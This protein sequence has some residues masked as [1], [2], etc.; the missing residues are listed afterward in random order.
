VVRAPAQPG[1][2]PFP[3]SR[4]PAGDS[5]S[6]RTIYVILLI[7]PTRRA[8]AHSVQEVSY[9]SA[10]GYRSSRDCHRRALR[11]RREVFRREHG[12]TPHLG[13]HLPTRPAVCPAGRRRRSPHS[14]E[15][16]GDHRDCALSRR[17]RRR[18]P[19]RDAHL[20]P[21]KWRDRLCG[22][23]RPGHPAS[24]PSLP[25][26]D[27]RL[28]S[29]QRVDAQLRDRYARSPPLDV[30]PRLVGTPD[31]GT[32]RVDSA[33]R[34]RREY[35]R[36]QY[37]RSSHRVR[38]DFPRRMGHQPAPRILRQL[39]CLPTDLR[40]GRPGP[41]LHRHDLPEDARP[42]RGAGRRGGDP[43]SDQFRDSICEAV[44]RERCRVHGTARPVRPARSTARDLPSRQRP[45]PRKGTHNRAM[46]YRELAAHL[47]E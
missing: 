38:R 13:H 28:R 29:G 15:P 26:G 16:R 2:Y 14:R 44:Q 41:P 9:E 23:S 24:R 6:F 35:R 27:R 31:G 37:R 34:R 30:S 36:R 5:P 39:R 22:T 11:R 25:P 32:R 3:T 4:G 42:E 47:G 10:R 45:D 8:G 18:H 46:A 7:P 21:R 40:R 33:Y 1:A 20:P 12:D 19:G 17:S 43:T